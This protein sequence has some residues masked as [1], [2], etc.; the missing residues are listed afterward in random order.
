MWPGAIPP[1]G[2]ARGTR[3]AR[4][5]L[6]VLAGAVLLL[7]ACTDTPTPTPV[8]S[9]SP[10]ASPG[11]GPDWTTYHGD[12]ARSGTGPAVRGTSVVWRARL[13]GAVYGQPL[14]L[15]NLVVAA[16]EHDSLYGL[17]ERTGTVRWHRSLG[18][19]VPRSDLPCGN[20]DPLGITG[21]PAYDPATRTV[22][23]VTE[24]TGFHHTLV[25]LDP[26]TGSVRTRRDLPS[27]HA[28][29]DQQRSALLV[30][31]G[32]VYVAFGGLYGDC[33]PYVGSVLGVP[34]S[35]DGPV[36]AYRV[37]TA[38]EGGSWATGG[39]TLGPDG[40]VYVSV[41]NGAATSG[42]YDGSDAVLALDANLHRTGYFAPAE[43]ADDNA[44]DLD[45]GSMSPAVLDS[46]RIVIAG[47]RGTGYLLDAARL[48]EVGGQLD[49]SA[50]CAAFGGPAHRGTIAYLPCQG[51]GVAAVDTTG[52][53]LR[54]RWHGP[55]AATGS[56]VLAGDR[57]WVADTDDGTLYA[58][59]AATGRTAATV[60][61]GEE[62]PHFASPTPAH[63]LLFTGT[64]HGVTAVGR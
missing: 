23:A 34:T 29:Y 16:T 2:P 1:T 9:G 39:P 13:D 48:G 50:V 7:T 3:R 45:L 30:A 4:A 44:N 61:L 54:L 31:H 15:G 6:A 57:L 43:W 52:D 14:V 33:G 10:A 35:G 53:R 37:P 58:L 49:S 32:H 18:T 59:D 38:R 22:F 11:T 20:I 41:G 55:A 40:T 60:R 47:K 51:G 62:L 63:G 8:R 17:D 12:G 21:T 36:L 28:Q 56:P 19:P 42:R 46:G 24:T 25:G 5:V 26:R 64:L 27:G